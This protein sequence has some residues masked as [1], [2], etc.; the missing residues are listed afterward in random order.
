MS[1]LKRLV[2]PERVLFFLLLPHLALFEE[3]RGVFSN[4]NTQWIF[5]WIFG[6]A[7]KTCRV[8]IVARKN[9]ILREIVKKCSSKMSNT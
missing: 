8:K 9:D 7:V 6:S 3:P 2:D 4:D 1:L 5:S